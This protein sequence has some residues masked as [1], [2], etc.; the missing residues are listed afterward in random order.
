MLTGIRP[1]HLILSMLIISGSLT[2]AQEQ[3]FKVERAPFSDRKYDEYSPVFYDGS[4]VRMPKMKTNKATA[5]R[6]KKTGTGK[7]V[8]GHSGGRHILTKKA[9]SRERKLRTRVVADAADQKALRRM[10]PN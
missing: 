4:T 6:F 2:H 9:T 3:P 1:Y 10:L 8:R 5:K 7:I